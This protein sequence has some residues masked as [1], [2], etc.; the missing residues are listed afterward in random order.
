MIDILLNYLV[1]NNK[2][3][4]YFNK[5]YILSN[6]TI[7]KFNPFIVFIDFVIVLILLS[8]GLVTLLYKLKKIKP[9]TIIKSN[10]S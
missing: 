3:L 2:E 1:D 5:F 7:V 8:L 4:L 9:I 10:K 6:I